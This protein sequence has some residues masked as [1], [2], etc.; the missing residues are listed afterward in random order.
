MRR[1]IRILSVAFLCGILAVPPIDAQ[2]RRGSGGQRAERPSGTSPSRPSTSSRPNTPPSRPGNSNARP[3]NQPTRPDNSNKKPNTPPP[4]GKPGNSPNNPVKPNN[5]HGRPPGNARPSNPNVHAPAPRPHNPTPPPP[6]PAHRP[7]QM[8][9]PPRPHRPVATPWERPLPPPAW[10]P[11]SGCPVVN[12]ILGITFG[13]TINISLNYL[14]NKGYTV[15]GYSSDVVYLRDVTEMSYYWPD[16]TLYYSSHG[17]ERSQ[18]VYSTGYYDMTRYNNLY[19][20]F[21]ARY[22]API[23]TQYSG[24]V[25]VA[26]WFGY[27]NSYIS[28]EFRPMYTSNGALRYYT[29]LTYGN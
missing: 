28:V 9:P 1:F 19:S 6:P 10:R 8:A 13:T 20:D 5:S 23:S 21:I 3:N 2:N 17:L 26:T 24:N 12:S 27:N 29:T 16:A 15:D 11:Y 22:G 7:P 25:R 14:Y 4:G 18:F